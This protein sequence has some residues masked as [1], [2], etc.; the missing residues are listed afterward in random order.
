MTTY[1]KLQK[2]PPT[3]FVTFS[4]QYHKLHAARA[5]IGKAHQFG[6]DVVRHGDFLDGA[7]NAVSRNAVNAGFDPRQQQS[8]DPRYTGNH[9]RYIPDVPRPR[10]ER[11]D[12][13]LRNFPRP[14][15]GV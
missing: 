7:G 10:S 13:D 15:P 12:D 9:R 14:R 3:D 6:F 4:E 5:H 8:F 11:R 1:N 2:T